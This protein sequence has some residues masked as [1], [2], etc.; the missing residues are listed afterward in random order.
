[1]EEKII[2]KPNLGVL[3]ILHLV[4]GIVVAT[5]FWILIN[6]GVLPDYPKLILFALAGLPGLL[7]TE[8]GIL[9][10]FSKKETGTF[11]IMKI[12]G[13]KSKLKLKE[14][15]LL[16][17]GLLLAAAI[18]MTISGPVTTFLQETFFSTYSSKVNLAQDMSIFSKSIITLTVIVHFLLFTLVY[19]IIEEL[20]FRGFLLCRMEKLG[21]WSVL[22]N[23]ILFALYH[24]WSPWMIVAR[25]LAFLPLFYVVYK[26]KSLKLSMTVHCLA[27]F[28]DV[29]ALL[30]LL[31]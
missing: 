8:L 25:T 17:T 13:L 5:T 6:A 26:K 21:K 30:P 24:L 15:I 9:F 14:F 1:M 29:I 31:M 20:Y 19:P 12:I 16:A 10:Y 28:T 23:T 22:L 2:A 18:L 3:I 27:N 4:P 11:N 7:I